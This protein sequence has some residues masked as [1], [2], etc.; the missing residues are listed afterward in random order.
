MNT[1]KFWIE[2][3]TEQQALEEIGDTGYSGP[4]Q[5]SGAG[6]TEEAGTEEGFSVDKTRDPFAGKQ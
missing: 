3:V 1:R 4:M 2:Q 5:Q 6:R